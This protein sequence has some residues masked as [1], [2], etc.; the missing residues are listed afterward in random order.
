MSSEPSNDR[1]VD[2]NA[3]LLA[4]TIPPPPPTLRERV[5]GFV[6]TRRPSDLTRIAQWSRSREGRSCFLAAL[7]A[8]ALTLGFYRSEASSAA[9]AGPAAPM[10]IAPASAS[11]AASASVRSEPLAL[12]PTAPTPSA[13][14]R[15]PEGNIDTAAAVS[16]DAVDDA[17]P[18]TALGDATDDADDSARPA[19]RRSSASKSHGKKATKQARK[20]KR[21]AVA[22]G[23]TRGRQ[24]AKSQRPTA[25]GPLAAWLA[26]QRSKDTSATK[27]R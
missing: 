24:S 11:P 17:P 8:V 6:T 5:A 21:Q 4:S 20:T 23:S 27:R 22:K 10:R 2:P 26:T 9:S 18:A 12:T 15:A 13:T 1:Y 3:R 14:A 7:A 16:S 19:P 25:A